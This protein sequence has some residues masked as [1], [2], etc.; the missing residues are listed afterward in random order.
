MEK[1]RTVST[2]SAS[3]TA[4]KLFA[5]D[6]EE[7]F[8]SIEPLEVQMQEA[9]AESGEDLLEAAIEYY[10]AKV[11]GKVAYPDDADKVKKR[12]IR[13]RAES[14]TMK[15]GRLMYRSRKKKLVEIIQS[16]DERKMIVEACHRDKT[17]G[18]FGVK[19]TVGRVA[20]KYYWRGMHKQVEDYVSHHH[21]ECH[22]YV[23]CVFMHAI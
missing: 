9:Q 16:S 17:S 10:L 5:M 13:K 6:S 21:H 4:T 8:E 19:K 11:D 2:A 20:A 22:I 12:N 15:A 3:T 14:I 7:H 23:Y 18:H 1:K